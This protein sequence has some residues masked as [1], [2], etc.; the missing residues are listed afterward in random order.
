MKRPDWRTVTVVA[1]S[2]GILAAIGMY[3]HR[4]AIFKNKNKAQIQQPAMVQVQKIAADSVIRDSIVQ[5][6][7]LEAVERVQV[8]PRVTG[9]LEQLCVKQGAR[10]VK[11]QTIATLEHAQQ[12]ALIGS[13]R[14]SVASAHADSERARAEMSNA[15]TN[16]ERY[17]RL[18]KEGFSTQQQYDSINTAYESAKASYSAAL[19]REHAAQADLGRVQSARGDYIMTAPIS[20]VVL[21]DYSLTTGAMISPSSPV[22]D[23]ADLRWLKAT[24]KVP[25]ASLFA[26]KKGMSVRLRLDAL[27]AEEF[28]GRVSRIDQ[29]VDPQTR[30]A[31]VEIVLDN[32]KTGGR[33]L[34]GMFGQASVITRECRNAIVLPESALH[35]GSGGSYVLVAEQ[36]RA[37]LKNVGTGIREN[38]KVQITKGLAAGDQVIVFGGSTLNGGEAVDVQSR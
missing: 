26:V 9:R 6:T 15:K 18:L 38:G 16:V 36:G 7:S 28:E 4:D 25:E 29:Y 35:S 34:P 32:G 37:K 13:T 19:A 12:D 17:G 5:N 23:V 3:S 11:G 1:V 20:G 31:A 33:L 14:A 30:T 22:A 2:I 24:L 27:P 21:N 8:L 10:V